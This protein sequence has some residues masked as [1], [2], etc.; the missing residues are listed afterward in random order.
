LQFGLPGL[1]LA[2][3]ELGALERIALRAWAAEHGGVEAALAAR[4]VP[5]CAAARARAAAAVPDLDDA[6]ILDPFARIDWE[7]GQAED[8]ARAAAAAAQPAAQPAE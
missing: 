4:R 2:P 3:A 6:V 1:R 5:A 7:A 8:A